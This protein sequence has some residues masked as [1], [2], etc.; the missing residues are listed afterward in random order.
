MMETITWLANEISNAI[1]WL[2]KEDSGC[3]TIK[4]DDRLAVC[5]GWSDGYDENDES[6]IH[7]PTEP[8]W[9]ITAGIKVWTS[10]SMRTDYDWINSPYYDD[11]NVWYNDISIS[12][13]ENF[14]ECAKWF[15]EE[16]QSLSKLTINK[17]GLI[18]N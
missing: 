16:Y 5:V 8:S 13:K 11:G 15:L 9:C 2:I 14:I 4:L 12:P 7:S 18:I 6:L 1:Y 3:V 10:D 17:N